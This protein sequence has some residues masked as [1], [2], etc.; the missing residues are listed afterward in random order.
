MAGSSSASANGAISAVAARNASRCG[1]SSRRP[2]SRTQTVA[3]D[4]SRAS[5]AISHDTS[6]IISAGRCSAIQCV[7]AA[8]LCRIPS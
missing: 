8:T 7:I 2:P 5:I 6:T 4:A 1:T 3:T